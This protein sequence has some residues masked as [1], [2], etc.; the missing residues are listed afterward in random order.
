MSFLSHYILD[1]IM[2]TQSEECKKYSCSIPL[3]PSDSQTLDLAPE[4]CVI[5]F[6]KCSEKLPELNL[7]ECLCSLKSLISHFVATAVYKEE[8]LKNR[9]FCM[10][11]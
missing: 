6:C 1:E 8:Y 10:T 11:L 2:N 9:K 3:L 7:C 4:V 5:D